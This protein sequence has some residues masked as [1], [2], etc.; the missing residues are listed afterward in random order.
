MYKLL[1]CEKKER[2][3][4][5]RLARTFRTLQELNGVSVVPAVSGILSERF[6]PS[7]PAKQPTSLPQLF[8][9]VDTTPHRHELPS[10]LHRPLTASEHKTKKVVPS[11]L[12]HLPYAFPINL[13][14]KKRRRRQC[15][16]NQDADAEQ[17]VSDTSSNTTSSFLVS[18]TKSD[19]LPNADRAEIQH[20]SSNTKPFPNTQQDDPIHKQYLDALEHI[21]RHCA[22]ASSDSFSSSDEDDDASPVVTVGQRR[23]RKKDHPWMSLSA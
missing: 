15:N 14:A 8:K 7:T 12:Q 10:T 17:A 1:K 5:R 3:D 4:L 21:Q 6:P 13:E 22:E 18:S 16:G 2:H 19:S 20:T 23:L 11:H 9:T